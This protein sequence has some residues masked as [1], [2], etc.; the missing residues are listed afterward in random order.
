MIQ[1]PKGTLDLYG[2]DA[3]KFQ[4]LLNFMSSFIS[5]YNY[6]YIKIPTFE[7]SELYIKSVGETSDIVKKETYDFLD[8]SKRKLTLRPEFTAG[9]VR[10]FLENKLYSNEINKFYYYGSAFRYE[11]PQQGRYREHTQFGVESFGVKSEY[12]DAEVIS[13]AFKMLYNLGFENLSVK[14]NS[15]GDSKS[16]EAYKSALR[17]YLNDKISNLCEDCKSRFETNILRVLDCKVDKDSDVFKNI[18]KITDYFT[19]ESKMYFNNLKRILDILEVPYEEDHT[20]VRGLDYYTDIVFEIVYSKKDIGTANT[21]CGGGRYD[22]LIESLGGKSIPAIGFAIGVE[23][24][25]ILLSEEEIKIPMS[26]PDVYVMNLEVDDYACEITDMLR[27]NGFV[28]DTNYQSK[29]MKAQFKIADDLEPSYIIIIGLDEK[30]GNYV[31]VKDNVTKENIKVEYDE[32][33]NYLSLNI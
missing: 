25:M 9:V 21:I 26:K 32:L 15:L 30:K 14:L 19:E 33:V 17:E 16:K 24:L 10:M 20:L 6:K 7:A 4:Y 13:L 11:R 8:K 2:S 31:T 27:N 5:L 1:K 12:L 3:E 29:S 28:V 23:R 22:D 18:P